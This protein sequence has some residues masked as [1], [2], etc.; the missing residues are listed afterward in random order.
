MFNSLR[1][2]FLRTSFAGETPNSDVSADERG[3][4]TS[5]LFPLESKK[6]SYT[7]ILT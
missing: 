2:N 4:G 1:N 7:H 6:R 3:G 5:P